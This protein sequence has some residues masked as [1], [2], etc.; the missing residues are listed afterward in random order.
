MAIIR[1]IFFI[2]AL[3]LTGSGYANDNSGSTPSSGGIDIT[4]S[5]SCK[6]VV[7]GSNTSYANT[8]TIAKNKD[9]YT[10]QWLNSSGKPYYYGTGVMN[11]DINAVSVVFWDPRM[12]SYFGTMLYKVNQDGELDGDW[13]IQSA[14][15]L[16]SEI[17]S[18][19]Y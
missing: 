4:G 16:G 19:S 6:G 10:F 5:Y 9:T 12:P 11:T 8:L 3:I 1:N 7:P 14:G 2:S 17:C 15:Q 18:R 13:L